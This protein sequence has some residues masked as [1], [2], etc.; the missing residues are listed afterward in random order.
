M[1]KLHIISLLPLLI[2]EQTDI[3]YLVRFKISPSDMIL[4]QNLSHMPHQS[5]FFDSL[6]GMV[7]FWNWDWYIEFHLIT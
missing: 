7:N 5:V 3:Y 2:V 4:T 1:Q 6:Y